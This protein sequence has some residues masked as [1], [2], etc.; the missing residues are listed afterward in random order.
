MTNNCARM[1]Y[2]EYRRLSLP[3]SRALV[4]STIKQLTRR[5]KGREKS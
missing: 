5:V 1:D 4:E 2:P 3:I